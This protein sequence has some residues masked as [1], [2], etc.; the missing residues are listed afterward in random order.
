MPIQ[1]VLT[2]DYRYLLHRQNCNAMPIKIVLAIKFGY[3]KEYQNYTPNNPAN[4]KVLILLRRILIMHIRMKR[5]RFKD[6]VIKR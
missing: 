4:Y 1:I 5:S 6:Q 2:I 3:S